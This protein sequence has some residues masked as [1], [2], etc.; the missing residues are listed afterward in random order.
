MAGH[1]LD[2]ER[3]ATEQSNQRGC[4]EATEQEPRHATHADPAEERESDRAEHSQLDPLLGQPRRHRVDQLTIQEQHFEHGD[5]DLDQD[6]ED[7][8]AGLPLLDGLIQHLNAGK[9]AGDDD[10]QENPQNQNQREAVDLVSREVGQQLAHR[11]PQ[12]KREDRRLDRGPHDQQD[13]G[14]PRDAGATRRRVEHRERRRDRALQ[15][16]PDQLNAQLE[17]S[18]HPADEHDEKLHEARPI[19]PHHPQ[20]VPPRQR[21]RLHERHRASQAEGDRVEGNHGAPDPRDERRGRQQQQEGHPGKIPEGFALEHESKN[22]RLE[23]HDPRHPSDHPL[24]EL[25]EHETPLLGLY[26]VGDSLLHRKSPPT[27]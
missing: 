14:R 24:H 5:C 23:G 20:R 25:L 13:E 27:G 2:D 8:I 1:A 3:L 9:A 4:A 15:G 26:G 22:L 16:A 17:Q 18:P 11:G 19:E 12:G 6:H 21:D 10:R 7:D